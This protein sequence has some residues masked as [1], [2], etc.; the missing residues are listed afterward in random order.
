MEGSVLTIMDL[1]AEFACADGILQQRDAV[2]REA[3]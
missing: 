2:D 3:G 1:N